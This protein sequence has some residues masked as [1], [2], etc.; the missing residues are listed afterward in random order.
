MQPDTFGI[1]GSGVIRNRLTRELTLKLLAYLLEGVNEASPHLN[2]FSIYYCR[3]KPRIQ[4]SS[5]GRIP[6]Y[7][8]SAHRFG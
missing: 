8:G 3:L 1:D 7:I 2:G 6:P 5:D 4:S